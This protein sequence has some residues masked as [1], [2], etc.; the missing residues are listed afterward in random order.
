MDL[1]TVIHTAISP[2]LALLPA[3]MDSAAARVQ[4]LATGLQ[5]SL[6]LHR[7]QLVGKPPSPIGPAKSY[8]QG[9]EGGGMVHGVRLH[10]ATRTLAARLYRA[11][12]VEA[13]DTAI[14]NAIEF[15]DVLAA[16]L[17]RLLLWSDPRPLPGMGDEE[18]AWALYLRTWRPGAYVRGTPDK[19]A[20]LRAKWSV[21]YDAAT[22]EVGHAGIG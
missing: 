6:F 15:D 5:E 10:A 14:W 20:A 3:R 18:A 8:W 9:E 1:M 11:R 4:L 16:G 21:S 12:N 7:R 13:N 17:A 22:R 2:A 19:Q